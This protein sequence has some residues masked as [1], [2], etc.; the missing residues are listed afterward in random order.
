M[1][2]PSAELDGIDFRPFFDMVVGILFVLLILIGALI[3][4]QQTGDGVAGSP[5]RE[6]LRRW[7]AQRGL[8][9]EH[10]AAD[11]VDRGLPARA[12]T[13]AGAV[14]VG[15][16]ALARPEEA[17]LPALRAPAVAELA[18][19]LAPALAC[20]S[21][22]RAEGSACGGID[23][24]SLDSLS[25]Q[26]RLGATPPDAAL[27]RDRAARFLAAALSTALYADAPALLAASDRV[28]GAAVAFDDGTVG[29][30]RDGMPGTLALAFA[31][32]RPR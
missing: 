8:F 9:L 21:L 13:A 5:S 17:G 27:P 28:G 16:D 22:P 1:S 31:F 29:T 30:G 26:V 3:F 7:R 18:A 32:A 25:V 11:L 10:L 6:E 14:L 15:L 24:L 23:L 4:F 19:G 20:V 2:R 12:D